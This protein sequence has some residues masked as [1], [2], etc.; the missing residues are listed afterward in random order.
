VPIAFF[1]QVPRRTHGSQLRTRQTRIQQAETR[2]G[3]L[4]LVLSTSKPSDA[5]PLATATTIAWDT[6][7]GLT[8]VGVLGDAYRVVEG[9]RQECSRRTGT[10]PGQPESEDFRFK[11]SRYRRPITFT[12]SS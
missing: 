7:G 4:G 12:E 2:S 9:S 11:E 5:A 8:R 1:S 3:F 6:I 10:L